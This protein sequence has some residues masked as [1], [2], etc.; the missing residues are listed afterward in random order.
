MSDISEA[1]IIFQPKGEPMKLV[2]TTAQHSASCGHCKFLHHTDVTPELTR[3]Y[4]CHRFP[5][6]VQAVNMQGRLMMVGQF[7]P[8]QPF[9]WCGEYSV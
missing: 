1:E 4:E 2:P 8:V 9:M 6:Q 5:P 7:P 3:A